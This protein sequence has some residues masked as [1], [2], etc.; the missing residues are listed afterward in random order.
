MKKLIVLTAALILFFSCQKEETSKGKTIKEYEMTLD[1]MEINEI[2]L[3][4]YT[5]NLDLGD[6]PVKVKTGDVLECHGFN[7]FSTTGGNNYCSGLEVRLNG[8]TVYQNSCE[9][10]YKF[11]IP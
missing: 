11:I 9:D 8:K 1:K 10:F 3:N 2:R 6:R 4:N 7:F 5:M